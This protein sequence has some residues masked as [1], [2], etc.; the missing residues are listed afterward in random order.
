MPTAR[1]WEPAGTALGAYRWGENLARGKHYKLDGEQDPR[2]ADDGD[3]LSDGIIAPPDT[4]VSAKYM[5]TNVMFA[6]NVSPVVT[7]DLGDQQTVS[8][9]RVHAGQEGGFHLTFPD[10]IAVETSLDDQM[11]VAAGAA[12]FTQVFDPPADFVP[13][14]LDESSLFDDLPAGGRLAYAYRILFEQPTAARY[15]RVRALRARAGA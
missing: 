5:P 9:V 10:V 14:E 3:D 8:A 2:N 11:Y 7:L 1:T 12:E 15:V 13:W 6:P 4:Y